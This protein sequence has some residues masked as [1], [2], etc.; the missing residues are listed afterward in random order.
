M[1]QPRGGGWRSPIDVAV[2][3]VLAREVPD[4]TVAEMCAEYT[5]GSDAATGQRP[6]ASI[7]HSSART[8]SLNNRPRPSE[9]DRPDVV[10]QRDAFV[11]WRRRQNPNRLVFLDEAGAISRW[12]ARMSGFNAVKSTWTLGR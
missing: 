4:A 6:R 1:Q 11:R 10:A 12:A 2:L 3:G 5:V 7:A 9:V 8:S